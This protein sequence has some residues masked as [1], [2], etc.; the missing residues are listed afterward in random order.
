MGIVAYA[1]VPLR[2]DERE[3]MGSFCAIDRKPR[4]WDGRELRALRD[5]GDVIEGLTALRQAERLPPLTLEDFR[6]MTGAVGAALQA[7]LRLH[8]AGSALMSPEERHALI[9]LASDLGRQ[10]AVVSNACD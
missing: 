1:G 2:M 4:D 8:E 9:A 5:A 7:A 3:T 6:T 10:L